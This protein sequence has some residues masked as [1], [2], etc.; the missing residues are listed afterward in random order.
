MNNIEHKNFPDYDVVKIGIQKLIGYSWPKF[1]YSKDINVQ[2]K[3]VSDILGEYFNIIPDLI[4][5]H[6]S[7][8]KPLPFKYYR[9]R[10]LDTFSDT[11]LISEYSY[12]PINL[13]TDIQRCNFPSKPV[14]YCS[15]DA[16]TALIEVLKDTSTI[17]DRK[18]LVSVW[19]LTS[20]YQAKVIPYLFGDLPDQNLFK[21]FGE[22]ALDNIPTIFG[23]SISDS[24]IKGLKLYLNFLASIF[25]ED[26]YSVSASLAHRIIYANHDYRA[27]IFV[28]PSVKSG[29]KSINFAIHPNFVD[30][31]MKIIRIYS[32]QIQYINPSTGLFNISIDKYADI[33]GS[34]VIWKNIN[35]NDNHYL[36]ILK[37]DFRIEGETEFRKQ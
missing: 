27:D 33:E 13:T 18:F 36:E 32:V 37:N 11:G 12:K 21:I 15:N 34:N 7:N 26:N 10:P 3:E 17:T 22:K 4:S 31:F 6:N 29:L 5:V 14:F 35:P 25:T 1:D 16:G 28:Y 19:T 9:V 24:Q 23:D 8:E 20:D 2:I 30:C